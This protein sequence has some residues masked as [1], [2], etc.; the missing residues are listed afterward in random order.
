VLIVMAEI[1]SSAVLSQIL[2][3]QQLLLLSCGESLVG[4]KDCEHCAAKLPTV[5]ASHP[6]L[7]W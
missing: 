6:P 7:C 1:D 3:L 5:A 4:P 2:G